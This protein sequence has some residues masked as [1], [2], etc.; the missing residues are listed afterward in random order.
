MSDENLETLSVAALRASLRHHAAR[1]GLAYED[2]P[3]PDGG[4]HAAL[5]PENGEIFFAASPPGS[6]HL[7]LSIVLVVDRD[8]F[9]EHS[10]RI[11]AVT[12]R[13]GTSVTL[14]EDPDLE[15]GEVYLNL[16]FRIFTEGWN[17]HVFSLALRTLSAAKDGLAAEF[18]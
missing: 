5:A 17:G 13:Y 12:S 2:R 18:P 8:F 4:L 7:S 6:G 3:A 9:H 16:S 14:A 1:E 15:E 11:L 10:R